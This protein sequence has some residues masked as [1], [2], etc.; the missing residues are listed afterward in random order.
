MINFLRTKCVYEWLAPATAAGI[1]FTVVDVST[2]IPRDVPGKSVANERYQV[3]II[4]VHNPVVALPVKWHPIYGTNSFLE[5]STSFVH[6]HYS[7]LF[8]VSEV[9]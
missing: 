2:A 6:K 9:Q 7:K 3:Y 1:R 4:S 8:L 5:L